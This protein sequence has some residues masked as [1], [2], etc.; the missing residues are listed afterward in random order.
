MALFA[1]KGRH[2]AHKSK[3]KKSIFPIILIIIMIAAI[4][5]FGYFAVTKFILPFFS[6][7]DA[8]TQAPTT[9]INDPHLGAVS[10]PE[11]EGIDKNEYKQ[12]N[13][14]KDENGFISYVENGQ[15]KSTLGVDLSYIQQNVD[16]N[17]LKAQGID[18]VILR[19]GGRYYGEEGG[20]YSDDAFDSHYEQ[21]K[22]AGLKVGA[23]FF[24]QSIT[25]LEAKE[26]AQYVVKLLNGRKLDFPIAFDWEFI[27][28]DP[29]ARTHGIANDMLSNMAVAFC[30]EIKS[31]GYIPM[32][33]IN[34]SLIYQS[35]DLEKIKG[36]DFWHSEYMDKPSLYFDFAIWQYTK[37]GTV[38]GIEGNVDIN[39]CMKE[40]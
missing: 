3:N 40:Y 37:T 35:Y 26:E 8:P 29:Q 19:I 4:V 23:Y 31:A 2:S 1:T 14:V 9:I 5:V 12:E 17:Q 38:A 11:V 24:S 27:D 28:E 18:F 36:Y 7:P 39:V 30:E 20:L 34:S 22:A 13:F 16:F 15:T 33:Y 21:A 32:I 10:V 6:T 25:E